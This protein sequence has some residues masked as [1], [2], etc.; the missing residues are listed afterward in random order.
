[1]RERGN[2]RT[3]TIQSSR[4]GAWL[5]HHGYSIVASL[6]RLLRKPWAT[7]LT[8]A[9]MALAL[10][11]PL[12]LWVVLQNVE[13]LGGEVQTSRE[14]AVFLRP[15]LD[16]ARVEALATALRRRDDVAAVAVVAPAPAL[17]ALKARPDIAAAIA[18]LGE[19]AAAA[20]LPSLLRIVPRGDEVALAGALQPQRLSLTGNPRIEAVGLYAVA[21]RLVAQQLQVR[22]LHQP[23]GVA[24]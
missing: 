18:V 17:E 2:E 16:A 5:D 20:A 3:A 12:G 19:E 23:V 6:G 22:L 4:L 7:L 15:E 21:F 13:R 9:V 24:E 8:V 1:M 11:L 10:A 14:V